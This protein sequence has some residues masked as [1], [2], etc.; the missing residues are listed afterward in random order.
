[1][2]FGEG[3]WW[4][5]PRTPHHGTNTQSVENQVIQFHT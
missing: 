3:V 2:V 4:F 5:E 1:V